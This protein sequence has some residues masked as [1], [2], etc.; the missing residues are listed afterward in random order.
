MD[1]G[2]NLVVQ[3]RLP[4]GEVDPFIETERRHHGRNDPM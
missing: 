2:G 3:N 4:S 1:S